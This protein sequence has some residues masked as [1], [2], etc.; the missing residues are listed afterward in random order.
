M[1]QPSKSSSSTAKNPS[2]EAMRK[3]YGSKKNLRSLDFT[4]IASPTSVASRS[5]F[6]QSPVSTLLTTHMSSPSSVHEVSYSI[7]KFVLFFLQNARIHSSISPSQ[8]EFNTKYDKLNMQKQ[9][10]NAIE[11]KFSNILAKKGISSPR[12][13]SVSSRRGE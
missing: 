6:S 13:A 5:T 10:S 8:N 3:A 4:S 7:L 9:A 2:L 1:S 12:G 11:S